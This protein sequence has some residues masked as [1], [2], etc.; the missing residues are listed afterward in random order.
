MPIDPNIALS[1]QTGQI[2]NPLAMQNTAQQAALAQQ[3]A[4]ALQEERLASAAQR[5]QTTQELARQNAARDA[6]GQA[7]QQGNGVREASRQAALRINPNAVPLV[8]DYFDKTEKSAADINKLNADNQETQQKL[9]NAYQDHL[10]HAADFILNYAQPDKTQAL[11]PTKMQ[12][13]LAMTAIH[14]GDQFPQERQRALQ[15]F[16]QASSMNPQQ[17]QMQLQQWRS[18][19]PYYQ[20]QQAELMKPTTVA[21]GGRVVLPATG[22]ILAQGAQPVPTEAVLDAQA[23]AYLSKKQQ[24]IATTPEEDANFK[25]YQVRKSLTQDQSQAFALNQQNR[26]FGQQLALQ[27]GTQ[28]YQLFKDGT[29]K[30]QGLEAPFTQ[31]QASAQT[32]RDTVHS[33]QAGNKIGASMQN[34][35]TTMAA[36]RAQGINR[37]NIAEI[38]IPGMS[39][40]EYDHIMSWLGGATAGQTVPTNIQDDMIKF[41]DA[42]EKVATDKYKKQWLQTTQRYGLKNEV[43]L[44]PIEGAPAPGSTRPPGN[45]PAVAGPAGRQPPAVSTVTTPG[46]AARTG[47]PVAAAGGHYVGEVVSVKGKKQK[48]TSIDPDGTIHGTPQ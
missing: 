35:E 31:A 39:G 30:M 32:L 17:L 37:I 5:E 41:S 24:G 9:N 4:Q 12:D 14:Y 36:I 42:I 16:Q 8:D 2:A 34:L 11:D 21:Q 40:N 22:Q 38:G 28:A 1:A 47:A 48:I 29:D 6:F 33:A 13:A 7:L 26:L 20:A 3:S 45:A 23:Q 44:V 19:A 15:M 43:P 25:A 18:N 10:G 27:Q 46:P